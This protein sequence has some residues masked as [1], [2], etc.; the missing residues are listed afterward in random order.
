MRILRHIARQT[1]RELEHHD[2]VDHGGAAA[3]T[4]RRAY[5]VGAAKRT[6]ARVADAE[7]R[8]NRWPHGR[9]DIRHPTT[10]ATRSA[11]SLSQGPRRS[12][13]ASARKARP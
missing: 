9:P 6:G 5:L 3:S 13:P 2:T 11:E 1:Q 10:S 8:R 7:Q 4:G 12:G